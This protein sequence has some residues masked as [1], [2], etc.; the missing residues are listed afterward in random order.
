MTLILNRLLEWA[1]D[2]G[3][4]IRRQDSRIIFNGAAQN[5]LGSSVVF[6]FMTLHWDRMVKA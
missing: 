5:P 6:D 1:L 2:A 3:S 4:G